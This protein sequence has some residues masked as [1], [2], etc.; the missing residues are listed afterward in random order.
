MLLNLSGSI[1]F[2]FPD[3]LKVNEIA[4]H[5]EPGKGFQQLGSCAL[6]FD[7]MMYGFSLGVATEA[8]GKSSIR[9]AVR[10]H[11]QDQALCPVQSNRLANLF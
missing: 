3:S 8:R 7:L 9:S 6:K 2:N 11:H 5:L 4:L 1:D 10:V